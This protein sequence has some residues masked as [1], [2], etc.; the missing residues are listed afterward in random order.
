MSADRRVIGT[1]AHGRIELRAEIIAPAR[2]TCYYHTAPLPG[3]SLSYRGHRD[4]LV[5]AG[6][7]SLEQLR[8]RFNHYHDDGHGGLWFLE[9]KAG[10]GKR[11]WLEVRYHLVSRARAQQLP[12]VQAFCAEELTALTEPP[13]GDRTGAA[14]RLRELY[15]FYEGLQ[16]GSDVT[17]Q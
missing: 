1:G 4:D 8:E 2:M 6:V 5:A 11:G 7:I 9:S 17:L 16:V 10:P 13:E 12:G 15:R 3:L 14:D